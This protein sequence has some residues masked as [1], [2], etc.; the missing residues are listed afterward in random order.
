MRNSVFQ[1]WRNQNGKKAEHQ[2]EATDGKLTF[3]QAMKTYKERL[4]GDANLK[5]RTKEY[6][7]QRLTALLK[8]W[9]GLES[10]EVRKITK[11]D[12]LNWAAKFGL[13]ASP[14]AFNHTV[15]VL[16]HVLEIGVETGV[17]YDN[18]GRFLKRVS[19][20]PKK[21]KLPETDLCI[22]VIPTK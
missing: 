3:G 9:P 21:L 7:G 10:T 15:S 18:P 1:I 14:T 8:S 17:R 19:E 13:K 20:S 12:C 16:R 6:H 11:T 5:P 22:A 4:E 2:I